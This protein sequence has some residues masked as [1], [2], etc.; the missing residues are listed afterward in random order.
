VLPLPGRRHAARLTAHPDRTGA[1]GRVTVRRRLGVLLLLTAFTVGACGNGGLQFRKDDRVD[2]TSPA[3]RARI[4]APLDVRWTTKGLVLGEAGGPAQF[5]V[6]VDRAPIRPGQSMSAVGDDAC[7]RTPGCPDE[8]Y[9]RDRFIYLTRKTSLTLDALP[10]KSTSNRYG[11][12]YAHDVTIVLVDAD[13][14]RRGESS[15]S[16]EF[17]SR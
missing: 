7:R 6:F 5:A 4:V 3:D 1:V 16:V 17:T 8:G 10:A 9:L 14:R 2:I 12:R 11:A 13:G 15:W